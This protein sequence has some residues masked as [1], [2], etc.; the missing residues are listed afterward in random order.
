MPKKMDLANL[1]RDLGFAISGIWLHEFLFH[2]VPPEGAK[3]L[4]AGCG[5]G[6]MGIH[7]ALMGAQ[8]VNMVDIDPTMLEY[9]RRLR[10]VAQL[11]SGKALPVFIS[12]ASIH[13][14]PYPDGFVDLAYNEGVPHHWPDQE[15]RQGAINEMA[16]VSRKWVCVIGSNALC[17]ETVKMAEETAHTYCGMPPKQ[18]PFT[19]T[20][21]GERLSSAG[22]VL[23]DVVPASGLPWEKSPLLVGWGR[24]P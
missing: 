12:D 15:R 16:R 11:L 6:K 14:L 20:E 4:E 21:L 1:Y 7:Y 5:S 10:D 9:A 8:A 19:P 17:P 22:L 3:V 23:V 24:K 18:K 2:L 13:Q